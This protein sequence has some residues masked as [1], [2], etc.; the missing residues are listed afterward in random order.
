MS[1]MISGL[2]GGISI[3]LG[4]LFGS[5]GLLKFMMKEEELSRWDFESHQV[6]TFPIL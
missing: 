1:S 2:M 4:G 5:L 6:L 3:F